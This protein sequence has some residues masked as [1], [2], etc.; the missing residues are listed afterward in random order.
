MM[1]FAELRTNC[2]HHWMMKKMAT[3][4]PKRGE[5]WLVDLG[6]AAKIRPC[7]ALSIPADDEN[8][9]VLATL[10]RWRAF[11]I[12]SRELLPSRNGLTKPRRSPNT[13]ICTWKP[14]QLIPWL[15]CFTVESRL[16]AKKWLR[17]TP[18]ILG[19]ASLFRKR[20]VSAPAIQ[21]NGI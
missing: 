10:S 16:Y 19:T 7:L 1:I 4:T 15:I 13:D 9:R 11:D 3:P 21:A 14:N 12:P 18:T 5:V 17:R 2:P 6:M 8:D 20:G